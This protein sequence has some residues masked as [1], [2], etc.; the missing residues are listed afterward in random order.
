MAL[1]LAGQRITADRLNLVTAK[2]ARRAS[3]GT[4]AIAGTNADTLLAFPTAVTTNAS[5]VASGTGNTGF[6]VQPGAWVIE[7]SLRQGAS[8]AGALYICAGTPA[9]SESEAITGQDATSIVRLASTVL[10]L[11]AVTKFYVVAYNAGGATTSTSYGADLNHV[12]F[13]RLPGF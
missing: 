5:V 8:T 4:Q 6:Q 10:L 7:A 3:D 12:S 13:T 11:S 2:Y 1:W 9:A